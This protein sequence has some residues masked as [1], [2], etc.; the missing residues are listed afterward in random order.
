MRYLY[1]CL[2][3]AFIPI[4]LAILELIFRS[5][6]S[7]LSI[8]DT[9]GAG[10]VLMLATVLLTVLAYVQLVARDNTLAF[11]SLYLRHWRKALHGFLVMFAIAWTIVIAAYVIVGL[12]GQVGWSATAWDDMT[13]RTVRRTVVALFV[14]LILATTEELMFRVFLMRYLR[15]NTT[16]AVT[17]GAVVFSS[18]VFAVLH[19]LTDPLSWLTPEGIRLFI[20][21]FLL[22]VLL[23][24]TYLVTGSFWCAVAVHA[25]LL[26]SKV[27]LRRTELLEVSTGS[28]WL[29]SADLRT[30]PLTWLV[31]AGMALLIYLLR[32]KL[33]A[34]FAIERP[35]VSTARFPAPR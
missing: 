4:P 11:F 18:L 20:G 15:W 22:A 13:V 2:F 30:T 32:R 26:G 16:P 19:N 27:F 1:I 14:V 25:G 8:Y 21:L 17:I 3:L 28:W 10:Q 24:T 5:T 6:G 33:H 35:V 12:F 31:F 7:G 34:R 29:D 9:R 23:C